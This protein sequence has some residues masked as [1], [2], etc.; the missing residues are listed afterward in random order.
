[1]SSE[2]LFRPA[3]QEDARAFYGKDPELSFRGY[4]A[5]LHGEVVGVGGVYY[6]AGGIPMAFTEM[7]EELAKRKKDCARACR[8]MVGYIDSLRVP[9]VYAVAD[10]NIETAPRLL[11]RLG[12]IPTG[13]ETERGELLVRRK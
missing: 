4:V 7:R 3:R 8:L 10:Q 2:V 13:H 11:R 12:F 6:D 5:E 1:M 9:T